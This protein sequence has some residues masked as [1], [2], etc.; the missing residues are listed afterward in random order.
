MSDDCTIM[1]LLNGIDSEEII[2]KKFGIE[3]CIYAF[4]TSTDATREGR[5]VWFVAYGKIYFGEK[6]GSTSERVQKIAQLFDKAGI[7]YNLTSDIITKQWKKFM[8]NIGMNQ[9]SAVLNATYGDFMKCPEIMD[10]TSDAMSE[11]ISVAQAVG[12]NLK[13]DDKIKALNS[14]SLLSPAGKTSMLQDVQAKRITEVNMLAKTL[15]KLGEIY[16]IAT[17]VNRVLYQQ[18]KTIESMY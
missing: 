14:F 18:I 5:K 13:D 11:A 2:G 3:K 15:I 16:N 7:E 8:V 4:I 10:L 9:V 17:P 12:V 1:S 6:D